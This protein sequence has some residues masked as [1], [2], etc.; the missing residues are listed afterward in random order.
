MRS[1]RPSGTKQAIWRSSKRPFG[2][3]EAEFTASRLLQ[4]IPEFLAAGRVAE[5]AQ[6]LGLDL[7]D[8]LAGHPEPLAD[9]FQR[10]LVA[11][12]QSKPQ[13]QHAPLPRRERVEH[14]LDLG[15]QHRERRG[16]GWR[17]RLAVLD[18]VTE[19]GVLL[20]SD[21]RLERDRILR[22]LHD[23]A[24]LLG[25]DPHLLADLLVARLAT[26]LLE[27]P[28]R[29]AHQLVD[30][31]H[32][33]HRDADRPRLVGDGARDGLPDPPRGVGRELVA[34]VVVELLD[35]PDE[36]H[37]AFLDE[38]EERHAAADVLLG[39]RHDQPQVGLG[40]PLLRLV[41]ALV[42]L[43][44]PVAGDSVGLERFGTN[45]WA[46]S[47]VG[48]APALGRRGVE[49]VLKLGQVVEAEQLLGDVRLLALALDR[50]QPLDDVRQ[51]LL[52]GALAPLDLLHDVQCLEG[53]VEGL[54]LDRLRELDLVVGR[55]QADSP[56]LLQVHADGVVQRDRIHHLDVEEH[57]VVDLLDLFEILLAIGDL[58][59]DLFE[60]GKDPEDLVRLGVDL[61][62]ALEDV[63]RGQVALLL[64]L[65][66]ELLG[67]GHQLVFELVLRLLEGLTGPIPT[68]GRYFGCA[69]DR[70]P[71]LSMSLMARNSSLASASKRATRSASFPLSASESSRIIPLWRPLMWSSLM[72]SASSTSTSS[73]T[74]GGGAAQ[75]LLLRSR[76]SAG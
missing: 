35:R 11:V 59:A 55:E 63:V 2:A 66:D 61:R 32:H 4:V 65:D 38:V 45:P 49:Q 5:L 54:G 57:L 40:Q 48:L 15:M 36:A 52:D 75:A 18:E 1:K 14:V 31:L 24:H 42:P 47:A 20:L 51:H 71:L 12:D 43:G 33:V 28:A 41:G 25:R 56:D 21:R 27:K 3:K 44:Q 22:D 23:L 7:R 60:R 73:S 8:A 74:L 30:R 26:E 10:A 6:R 37:V 64:A 76:S 50:V 53:V 46:G 17:D 70:H 9:L 39:D 58:Y 67:H 16:I 19:V 34:L 29:N 62:E 68:L 69:R 72:R 13:L